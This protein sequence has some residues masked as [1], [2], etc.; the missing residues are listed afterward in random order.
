[1]SERKEE[2][3]GTKEQEHK[4]T[5]GQEERRKEHPHLFYIVR[6]PSINIGSKLRYASHAS[7]F[8]LLSLI[9]PFRSSFLPL[10]SLLSLS[11][12]HTSIVPRTFFSSQISQGPRAIILAAAVLSSRSNRADHPKRRPRR[13]AAFLLLLL[14]K[15]VFRRE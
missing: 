2:R 1:M 9:H 12:L 14:L 4:S 5:R 11:P 8:L 7:P 10:P 6:P 3:E 15:L 13:G